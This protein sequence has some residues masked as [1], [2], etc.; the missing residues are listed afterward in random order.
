MTSPTASL[1]SLT[2]S[3]QSVTNQY[4]ANGN[5]LVYFDKLGQRWVKTYN[6]SIAPLLNLTR[7]ATQ[8]HP[9]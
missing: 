7:S 4:D 5:L 8:N 1:A 3:G 6:R 9:L 2:R